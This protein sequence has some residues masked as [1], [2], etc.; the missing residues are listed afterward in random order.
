MKALLIIS[1]FYILY[2]VLGLFGVQKIPKKYKDREWT[3]EYTR[4]QGLSYIF[5]GVPWLIFYIVISNN[6]LGLAYEILMLIMISLPSLVFALVVDKKY[7][8]LLKKG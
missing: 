4:K 1:I 5:L 2:G 7:K 8:N 3:M 6:R